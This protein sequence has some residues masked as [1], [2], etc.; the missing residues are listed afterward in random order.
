[1]IE[2][3]NEISEEMR[4][5]TLDEVNDLVDKM[6]AQTKKDLNERRRNAQGANRADQVD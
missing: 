4:T 3:S 5:L 6:V 2:Q 1:M